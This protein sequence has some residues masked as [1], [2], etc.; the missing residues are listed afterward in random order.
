LYLTRGRRERRCHAAL[1]SATSR[2]VC[3]EFLRRFGNSTR[4]LRRQ[5]GKASHDKSS[6]R[7]PE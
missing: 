5:T 7:W 6:N 3:A 4:T 2:A 1:P